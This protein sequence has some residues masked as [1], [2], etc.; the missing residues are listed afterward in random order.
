[1]K[2]KVVRGFL[3]TYRPPVA[4]VLNAEEAFEE[5]IYFGLVLGC[6]CKKAFAFLNQ[7]ET[8]QAIQSLH[9]SHFYVR[10]HLISTKICKKNKLAVPAGKFLNHPYSHVKRAS[11]TQ[12]LVKHHVNLSVVMSQNSHGN[13]LSSILC[14]LLL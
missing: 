6:A 12:Q 2:G 4:Q 11:P 13:I 5:I 1:M 7:W 10:F 8:E 3:N 14:S 9:L